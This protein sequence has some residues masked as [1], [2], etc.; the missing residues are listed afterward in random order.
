MKAKF[1]LALLAFAGLTGLA[2][3]QDKAADLAIIANKS[4]K[5]DNVSTADLKRYFK[6]EKTKTPDGTKLVVVA[7]DQGTPERAAALA[8]LYAMNEAEYSDYFVEATF[9]G[10]VAAAPKSL[11]SA[12]A[13]K[14]FVASTPGA[15]GYVKGSETDDSVQVLKIDGKLPGEAGYKLKVK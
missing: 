8:G 9:T 15:L 7:C 3:A 13:V 5:L 10:A 6:A 4:T 14:A 2:A 1:F 11:A 12:A